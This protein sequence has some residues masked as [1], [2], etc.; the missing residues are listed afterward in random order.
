MERIFFF[1][2]FFFDQKSSVPLNHPDYSGIRACLC[3]ML[4]KSC[5][6]EILPQMDCPED[7]SF[8][9]CSE[10]L[11]ASAAAV[12]LKVRNSFQ[13]HFELFGKLEDYGGF[14]SFFFKKNSSNQKQ[15]S[16]ML[17]LSLFVKQRNS[18]PFYLELAMLHNLIAWT[19][20]QFKKT[21]ETTSEKGKIDLNCL[22]G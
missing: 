3:R 22:Y 20:L 9:L 14:F 2:N 19:N 17:C 15:Q 10:H 16:K 11:H 4:N 12:P 7:F 13:K 21:K 5:A 18:F 8:P 6:F 1:L